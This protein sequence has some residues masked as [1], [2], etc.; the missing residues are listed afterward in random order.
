MEFKINGERLNNLRLADDIVKNNSAENLEEV[1]KDL[2][3]ESL[4]VT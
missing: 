4:K 2:Y 1:I 3:R